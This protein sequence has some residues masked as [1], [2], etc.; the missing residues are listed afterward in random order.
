M[1][2]STTDS[3]PQPLAA[4]ASYHA[5]VY[6]D[7]PEERAIALWLRDE[8]AAR[9]RLALGRVHDRLVG[10][11]ARPMYQVSFDVATFATLVPWLMLNRRGLSIM[12]HPNTEAE[13]DDHLERAL[14]LGTPLPILHADALA[15]ANEAQSANPANTSPHLAP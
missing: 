8:I 5:H 14:W 15:E 1:D 2:R 13:R 3:V 12:I 7:G 6:F 11:H 4:I 10:P 9:F